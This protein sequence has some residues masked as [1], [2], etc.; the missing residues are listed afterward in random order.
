M[1]A[2]NTTIIFNL[3]FTNILVMSLIFYSKKPKQIIIS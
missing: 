3:Y 1:V 2:L